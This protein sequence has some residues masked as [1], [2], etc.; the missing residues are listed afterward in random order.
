MYALLTYWFCRVESEKVKESEKESKEKELKDKDDGSNDTDSSDEDD[1][2]GVKSSN[3]DL[4]HI[5]FVQRFVKA[6]NS[7]ISHNKLCDK[8][9]LSLI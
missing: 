9:R 8:K 4:V 1:A 3:L 7:T 2:T 6:I 5:Y